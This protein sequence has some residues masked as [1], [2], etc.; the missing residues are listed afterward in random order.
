MI[1]LSA[2]GE[3]ALNLWVGSIFLVFGGLLTLAGAMWLWSRV[4]YVRSGSEILATVIKLEAG[5]SGGKGP[6]PYVP[7]YRFS[8]A[9]ERIREIRSGSNVAGGE[10]HLG[11]R[12][13]LIY[14]A[15]DETGLLINRFG[16]IYQ[17]PLFVTGLGTIFALISFLGLR[18][19][20]RV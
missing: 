8:D 9:S 6:P 4:D 11:E 7:T 3:R 16:V 12:V 1:Q 18:R 14:N 15:S 13:R 19:A 17:P 10:V 5:P 20:C 2:R